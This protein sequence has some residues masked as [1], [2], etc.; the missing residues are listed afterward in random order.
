M[1]FWIEPVLISPDLYYQREGT[2]RLY[3]NEWKVV[4]FLSVQGASNNV[5]RKEN[6]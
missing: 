6:T 4:I 3:A 2:A 5:D 1:D